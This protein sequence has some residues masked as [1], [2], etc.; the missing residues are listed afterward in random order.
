MFD[1]PSLVHYAKCI[2]FV[3]RT[4]N[5]SVN[6][7]TNARPASI[8]FAD[9][10]DLKRGILTSHLLPTL[11]SSHSTYITDLIEI[12]DKVLDAAKM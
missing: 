12:Q 5:S 1:T 9:N 3:Q 8:L 7:R 6:R 4:I 2:P 10:F 11:T